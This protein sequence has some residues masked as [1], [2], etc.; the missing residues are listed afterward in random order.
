MS[1]DQLAEADRTEFLEGLGLHDSGLD[2]VI[3]AGYD[4]LGLV[5]YFT[6]GPKETHAWTITKGTNAELTKSTNNAK[7]AATDAAYSLAFHHA[8][9]IR[10]GLRSQQLKSGRS[11][12]ENLII[13]QQI[14]VGLLSHMGEMRGRR[15]HDVRTALADN[16]GAATGRHQHQPRFSGTE[17]GGRS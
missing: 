1:D 13:R 8:A 3:R 15:N 10:S 17:D 16:R 7:P 4:L 12:E 11:I 9:V 5:T 14:A 2:R 6:C